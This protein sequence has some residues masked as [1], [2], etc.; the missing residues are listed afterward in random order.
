MATHDSLTF[1]YDSMVIISVSL[2]I[3]CDLL[4]STPGSLMLIHDSMMIIRV[5]LVHTS[6][7]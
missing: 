7:Y 6:A 5:S 4:M 1:I 2:M 3:T